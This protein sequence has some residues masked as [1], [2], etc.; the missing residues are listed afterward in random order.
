V[1]NDF[2]PNKIAKLRGISV[3][4]INELANALRDPPSGRVDEG[5]RPKEG[6]EKTRESVPGRRTMV[7]VDIRAADRPER[8]YHRDLGA[9]TTV[10]KMIFGRYTEKRRDEEGLAIVVA[11]GAGRRFGSAKQFALLGE[12]R[13][14]RTL[15]AVARPSGSGLRSCCPSTG[16]RGAGTGSAG[17][18]IR[19][20]SAAAKKAGF[21]RPGFAG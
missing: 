7:V 4:N 15:E 16:V 12:K 1:T 9:P 20:S 21:R 11:A 19:P 17:A 5:V 6:K 13:A 10:G 2:N 18:K 3:L 8:R 14:R